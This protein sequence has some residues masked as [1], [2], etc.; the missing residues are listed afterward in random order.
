MRASIDEMSS[1]GNR[2]KLDCYA[3]GLSCSEGRHKGDLTEPYFRALACTR[4]VHRLRQDPLSF[5]RLGK[6]T[7]GQTSLGPTLSLIPAAFGRLLQALSHAMGH[8]WRWCSK[9][10]RAKPPLCHHCSVCKK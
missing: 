4:R 10:N 3:W 6:A 7:S 5:E 8:D 9:C 1:P 2:R